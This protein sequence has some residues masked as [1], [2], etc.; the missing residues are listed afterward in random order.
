MSYLTTGQAAKF[1]NKSRSHIHNM[2]KSGKLSVAKV[3]EKGV[4]YF[5]KSELLRVFEERPKKH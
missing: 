2:A 3:D 4:R 1:V 5:D